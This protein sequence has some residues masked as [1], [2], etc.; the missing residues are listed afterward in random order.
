[1]DDSQVVR[2]RIVW[3]GISGRRL[4]VGGP[5][6]VR[7]TYTTAGIL[8]VAVFGQIVNLSLGLIDI[9]LVI[10]VNQSHSGR[11]VTTI[12]QTSQTFN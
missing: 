8:V 11:I 10:A 9:Q 2:L 6:G 1:M 12:L 3:M 4:S 5:A 7:N